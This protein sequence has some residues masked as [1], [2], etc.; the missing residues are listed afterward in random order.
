MP[1]VSLR[2][3]TETLITWH[4]RLGHLNA[5]SIYLLSKNSLG[6]KIASGTMVDKPCLA[7]L[8]RKQ[9]RQPSRVSISRTKGE[10]FEAFK[11]LH[12]PLDKLKDSKIQYLLSDNALEY[13]A[14]LDPRLAHTAPSSAFADDLNIPGIVH[15]YTVPY[16]PEQNGVAEQINRT[17]L[18][19]V[20]L[21]L[22]ENEVPPR[23]WAKALQ[24]ALY[25][26]NRAPTLAHSS[27]KTPFEIWN[28]RP[29][30]IGH[31]KVFGSVSHVDISK[32]LGNKLE[33][34]SHSGIVVGY[35]STNIYRIY[36]PDTQRIIRAQ[37]VHF[38]QTATRSFAE[39][40]D[41]NQPPL[42]A[43]ATT[44]LSVLPSFYYLLTH[45]SH[46]LPT[47]LIASLLV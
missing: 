4:R 3:A 44:H 16:R 10:V 30:H 22:H 19:M 15:E 18:E 25:L 26:R 39:I 34:H 21:M 35:K 17:L 9:Y 32:A 40:V 38:D 42:F 45:W 46:P 6:M 8:K 7:G 27:G 12:P 13:G 37:D 47:L 20:N 29:P 43:A 31:L 14:W 33:S 5:A 28:G 2:T 23:L 1:S 41:I 11:T 24:T 36:M